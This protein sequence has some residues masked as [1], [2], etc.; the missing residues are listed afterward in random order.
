MDIRRKLSLDEV[1]YSSDQLKRVFMS[2][3]CL[4]FLTKE[5]FLS[6]DTSTQ[7]ATVSNSVGLNTRD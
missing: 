2:F 4:F 6:E 3:K 7:E 5:T 1:F